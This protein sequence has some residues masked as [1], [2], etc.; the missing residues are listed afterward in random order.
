MYKMHECV[1]APCMMICS[2]LTKTK[3]TWAPTERHSSLMEVV[4]IGRSATLLGVSRI[5]KV[6]PCNV[7]MDGSNQ[8]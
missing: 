2:L 3:C 5:F 7:D 6:H 8:G 4:L 1:V